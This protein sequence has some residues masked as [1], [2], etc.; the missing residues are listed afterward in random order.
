MMSATASVII[1]R[2]GGNGIWPRTRIEWNSVR[3]QSLLADLRQERESA[4]PID[5]D[6]DSLLA[7]AEQIRRATENNIIEREAAR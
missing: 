4:N 3:L 2:Y 5:V 6:S 1:S 7:Q